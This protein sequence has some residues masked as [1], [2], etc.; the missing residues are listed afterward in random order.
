[1]IWPVFGT[2]YELHMRGALSDA[3]TLKTLWVTQHLAPLLGQGDDLT[4]DLLLPRHADVKHLLGFLPS[5]HTAQS[6]QAKR[7][8][9]GIRRLTHPMAFDDAEKRFDGIGADRQADV[10]EPEGLRGLKL[11]R[12]IGVKLQEKRGRGKGVE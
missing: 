10:I 4:C 6:R 8:A 1:M 12:K 7:H 2:R 9:I 3:Q 5:G 11:E